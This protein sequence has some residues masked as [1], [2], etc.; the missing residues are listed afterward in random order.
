MTLVKLIMCMLLRP[1]IRQKHNRP[2]SL[3]FGNCQYSVIIRHSAR[4]INIIVT[5]GQNIAHVPSNILDEHWLQML[6]I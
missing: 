6:I 1:D 2:Y 5:F 3:A 4:V